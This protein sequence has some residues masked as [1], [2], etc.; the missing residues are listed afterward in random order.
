[1][2]HTQ[3]V[4]SKPAAKVFYR[5]LFTKFYVTENNSLVVRL[6]KTALDLYRGGSQNA[7]PLKPTC[8]RKKTSNLLTS[9]LFILIRPV[10]K[11]V[12]MLSYGYCLPKN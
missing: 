4:L 11:R 5:V 1:M 10:R 3:S 6:K 8:V 2:F 7:E 12:L 9:K